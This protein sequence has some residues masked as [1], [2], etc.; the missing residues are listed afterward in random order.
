MLY[1]YP[2]TVE[3]VRKFVKKN[4]SNKEVYCQENECAKHRN[5]YRKGNK[6]ILNC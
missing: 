5:R 1:I 6:S 2:E 3:L 4:W